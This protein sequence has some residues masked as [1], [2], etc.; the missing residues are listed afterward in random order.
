[1]PES[2]SLRAPSPDGSQQPFFFLCRPDAT[3]SLDRP[4]P[5][6][7][8]ADVQELATELLEGLRDRA[9]LL[10]A[11]IRLDF[12][13]GPVP[14]GR[15]RERFSDRLASHFAGKSQLRIMAGVVG[16]GAMAGGFS[17]AARHC[18]D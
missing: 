14:S 13:F 5:A 6:D 16:L 12:R 4:E 15:G 2:D 7:P 8:F 10:V 9:L 11:M 3:L 18:A 1:V 17:A